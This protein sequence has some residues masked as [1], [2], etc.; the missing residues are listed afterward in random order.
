MAAAD[1][2]LAA[3]RF[4]SARFTSAFKSNDI[5]PEAVS[6]DCDFFL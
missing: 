5:V 4:F 3:A 1:S 2:L 6:E